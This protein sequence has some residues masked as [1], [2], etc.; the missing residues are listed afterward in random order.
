MRRRRKCYPEQG[1]KE[2]AGRM[3]GSAA[4]IYSS[5]LIALTGQPSRAS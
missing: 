1:K 5:M 3:A 2:T 4:G